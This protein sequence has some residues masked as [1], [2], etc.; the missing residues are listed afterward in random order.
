MLSVQI[1]GEMLTEYVSESTAKDSIG[2]VIRLTEK[3]LSNDKRAGLYSVHIDFTEDVHTLA[4][5][6]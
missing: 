2:D 5:W 3:S 1:K 4:Q 6:F